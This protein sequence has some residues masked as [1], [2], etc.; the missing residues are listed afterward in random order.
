[1][2]VKNKYSLCTLYSVHIAYIIHVFVISLLF[3]FQSHCNC[4]FTLAGPMHYA[5]ISKIM[6]RQT[7]NVCKCCE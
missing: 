4:A 1:M 3:T 7:I 2:C 5:R 6:T